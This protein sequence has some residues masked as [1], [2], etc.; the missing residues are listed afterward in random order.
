MAY[1]RLIEQ[2][3]GQGGGAREGLIPPGRELA[4]QGPVRAGAEQ[5]LPSWFVATIS[6][7]EANRSFPSLLRQVAQG[8]C[9]TVLSRGRPVAVIS[10]P[11]P[12]DGEWSK[13][14]RRA[15]LYD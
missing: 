13:P 8:E 15:D 10:R 11:S 14:R 1:V 5:L 12:P 3:I 7:S 6:A 9:F 4:H 2:R